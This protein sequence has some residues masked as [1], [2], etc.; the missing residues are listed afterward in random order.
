MLPLRALTKQIVSNDRDLSM[1]YE[2]PYNDELRE[3]ANALNLFMGKLRNVVQEAIKSSDEN[4]AVAHELSSTSMSIGQRA[5]QESDIIE[6]T[7]Q[8]GKTAKENILSSVTKS[9]EAQVEIG[10]TNKSLKET[11][12]DFKELIANIQTTA[13]IEHDLQSRMNTLA[14]D[15]EQVKDIL[16]VIND[17]ADQTNL[18]ALN[19]AIEAARAGE[20]GR[21]FA[22]VADEVRKLAERTQK[23][24]IEINATVNVI[25][26]AITDASMQMDQNGTLFITL[27]EQS[28]NVSNKI[29]SSVELMTNSVFTVETSANSTEQSGKE[30]EKAMDEMAHINQISMQ[31]VRDL[32][33]I[34]SAADHLHQVTQKLNDKLH[35]FK[36]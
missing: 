1:T 35:Y 33:E 3:I 26:Q 27:V 12:S 17:I 13:Q 2:T 19:A 5:E 15:A 30:I 32:E 14:N 10:N 22:V 34:A 28:Q 24:L 7:S 18:L 6:K 11:N 31:N 23:S 21:G 20:H 36:V 16:N 8:T 9:K 29:L 4:A 25:V